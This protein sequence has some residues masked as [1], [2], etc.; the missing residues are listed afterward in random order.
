MS[1]RS[2]Y[3]ESGRW[4]AYSCSPIDYWPLWVKVVDLIEQPGRLISDWPASEMLGPEPAHAADQ[5]ADELARLFSSTSGS[6]RCGEICRL[7]G[8]RRVKCS[9]LQCP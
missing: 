1:V 6:R 5:Y 7:G 9:S 8:R 2:D 3:S 4:Y